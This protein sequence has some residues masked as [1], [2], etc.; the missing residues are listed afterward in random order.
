MNFVNVKKRK[1]FLN[2]FRRPWMN[3]VDRLQAQIKE[4]Q[5]KCSH[6]FEINL[7]YDRWV[8]GRTETSEFETTKVPDV[9]VGVDSEKRIFLST[10]FKCKKCNI[11]G[12]TNCQE[13]CARCLGHVV[14]G[15]KY[16]REIFFGEGHGYYRVRLY[17]CEKCGFTIAVDEFD[18]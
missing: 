17:K 16:R 7:G 9:F 8:G 1:M 12:K 6:D 14:K 5:E 18:Q 3:E 10:G 15:E 2:F 11:M 4:I 13:K